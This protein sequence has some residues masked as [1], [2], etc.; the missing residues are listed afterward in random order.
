[1]QFHPQ[2]IRHKRLG[3]IKQLDQVQNRA[4]SKTTTYCFVPFSSEHPVYPLIVFGTFI[5]S[6]Y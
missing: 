2:I 1:M 6:K 5:K 4:R 3:D